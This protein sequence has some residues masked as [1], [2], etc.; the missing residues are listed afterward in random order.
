VGFFIDE[1]SRI[2]ALIHGKVSQSSGHEKVIKHDKTDT[3]FNDV[4]NENI[5]KNKGNKEGFVA[6]TSLSREKLKLLAEIIQAQL[7]RTFLSFG[8]DS[9]E[10]TSNFNIEDLLLNLSNSSSLID[11]QVSKI[12]QSE[13]VISVPGSHNI[14][15][16]IDEAS[17][18]YKVDSELIRSVIRAESDFNPDCTSS[19]GAMGLM[20]LMPETAKDLGVKRPYD[21]SENVMGG[22]NYLKTL[23]DRY[24]GNTDLALAAYNW[25]MGNLERN[26][27]NLPR[28][29][30]DYVAKINKFLNSS[31]SV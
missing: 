21:I 19:K 10:K 20:Q 22:T 5:E 24:E 13:P 11:S 30:R 8:N 23:L 16:V 2:D 25:G 4:L 3:S 31:S 28:E 9:E 7:K 27:E 26:P 29:T 17:K 12:K 15:N 18:K 14:E 1:I 6:P